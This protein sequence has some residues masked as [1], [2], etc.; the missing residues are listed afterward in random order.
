MRDRHLFLTYIFL[1]YIKRLQNEITFYDP[2]PYYAQNSKDPFTGIETKTTSKVYIG[3][4]EGKRCEFIGDVYCRLSKENQNRYLLIGSLHGTD[5]FTGDSYALFLL[6]NGKKLRF[7]NRYNDIDCG[8]SKAIKG[9]VTQAEFDLLR[10]HSI[11]AI[12][13]VGARYQA[14]YTKITGAQDFKDKLICIE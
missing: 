5:C 9:K 10:N 14:N 1:T 12:K 11:T 6:D 3:C 2:N 8:D 13:L 4:L 7:N